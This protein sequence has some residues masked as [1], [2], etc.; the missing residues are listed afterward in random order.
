[1][2]GRVIL[3]DEHTVLSWGANK[4]EFMSKGSILDGGGYIS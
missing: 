2:L 4:L 3:I 1:M